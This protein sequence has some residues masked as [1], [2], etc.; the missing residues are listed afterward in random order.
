MRVNP[1]LLPDLLAAIEQT[2][3]QINTGLEQISSGRRVNV[4]SDDPAAASVLVRTADQSAETDQFLYSLGSIEGSMQNA[5]SALASVVTALQRAISLGVAGANGTLNSTD[6]EAI[7]T[8][9]K[10]IQSQLVSLANLSYQGVFAFAGT[11]TQTAPY[12][13][14]ASAP[15]GVRYVGNSGVNRVT[16]GNSFSL[17]TNLPGSQLFSEPGNDIFQAVQDLITS[18]QSGTGIDNAVT[19]IGSAYN[20]LN[21]Q[22]VFYGNAVNQLDAQKTY[23]NSKNM[24]LSQQENTAG[25]ADLAAAISNLTKAQTSYEATLAAVAR[26]S[27]TNLFSFL[28]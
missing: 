1:N 22:R 4:P 14:D 13:L 11:S 7:V 23:L 19:A 10:G 24:Q 26:T 12:V 18:L 6:R 9:V 25:G 17:Q 8:E 2:Q 27:Q 20:H 3:Q 21:G 5:D 15:S 16:L 28:K